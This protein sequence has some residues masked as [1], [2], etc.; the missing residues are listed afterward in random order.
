MK[1]F[2]GGGGGLSGN[3]SVK[4]RKHIPSGMKR[5][6][7]LQEKKTN[8]PVLKNLEIFALKGSIKAQMDLKSRAQI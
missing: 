4:S 8:C 3:K 7:H 5:S 1:G 6:K 2:G